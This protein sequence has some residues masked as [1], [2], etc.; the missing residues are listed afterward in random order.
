MSPFQA[1]SSLHEGDELIKVAEVLVVVDEIL[2]FVGMD[3]DVEATDLGQSEL[4]SIHT[5][6]TDLRE[7][8]I[9]ERTGEG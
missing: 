6:E 3:N 9:N 1:Q 7:R 2:E 5:G 4:L 8:K